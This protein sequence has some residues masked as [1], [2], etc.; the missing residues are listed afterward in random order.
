MDM[1]DEGSA[2]EST[3]AERVAA[4]EERVADLEALADDQR[5]VISMLTTAANLEPLDPAECPDC[6]T[7]ALVKRSGL[8]WSKAL[9]T[10]CGADW[11]LDR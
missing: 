3:T 11:V 9:C 8:T 1:S 6:G 10:N 4:L 7:D 5:F 2:E